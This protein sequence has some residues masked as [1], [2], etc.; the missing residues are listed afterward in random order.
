MSHP[1]STSTAKKPIPHSSALNINL[2]N[3]FATIV[4]VLLATL[5]LSFSK[6]CI[7]PG[8]QE[9]DSLENKKVSFAGIIFYPFS[10]PTHI[11][12]HTFSVCVLIL[13]FLKENSNNYG[14]LLKSSCSL[15]ETN[16]GDS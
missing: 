16:L 4:F 13:K 1:H 6:P 8:L 15:H 5:G 9:P 3:M 10:Y 7:H 14:L 12:T 2:L 11:C